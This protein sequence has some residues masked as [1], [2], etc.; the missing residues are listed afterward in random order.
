[1]RSTKLTQIETFQFQFTN[2]CDAKYIHA[3]QVL[4]IAYSNLLE[5]IENIF[6]D[7]TRTTKAHGDSSIIKGVIMTMVTSLETDN[8]N[9]LRI[10]NLFNKC[11][12]Y[13]TEKEVEIQTLRNNK[14]LKSILKD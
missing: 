11:H 14:I 4:N 12:M 1:M 5:D 9:I 2:N 13:T 3:H 6:L 10:T 7:D 8:N